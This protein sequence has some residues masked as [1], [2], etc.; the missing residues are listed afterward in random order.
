MPKTVL[1]AG[2]TLLKEGEVSVPRQSGEDPPP[3]EIVRPTGVEPI[4]FGFG[5]QRS[6]QLSY[7]RNAAPKVGSGSTKATAILRW[8]DEPLND[9]RAAPLAHLLQTHFGYP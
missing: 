1:I 4:T 6:I 5:G 2:A 7:G 9:R 8:S 3:C